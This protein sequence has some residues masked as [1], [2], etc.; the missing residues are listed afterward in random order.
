M[1]ATTKD[2]D[3]TE[4]R[5]YRIIRFRF[6]GGAR[7]IRTG[8]TLSE[9]QAHCE[10]PETSSSTASERTKRRTPGRWFDGYDYIK[11][12]RPASV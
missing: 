6:R 10:D 12:F 5:V 9:A 3:N 7:T 2:C 1:S 4:G 8:L 11:G